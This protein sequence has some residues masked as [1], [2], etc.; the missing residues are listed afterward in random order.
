MLLSR[1]SVNLSELVFEITESAAMSNI[2]MTQIL[3]RQLR[4]LGCSC[5]LDNF[6]VGFSSFY[7]LK[8]FDVDYLKIDGS[9][10]SELATDE[11]SRLFVRSLCDV[12]KGLNKHVIAERVETSEVL[13]LLKPLGVDF[14]QGHHIAHPK[15]FIVPHE[16]GLQ[17]AQSA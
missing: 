9:F 13:A 15:P 16:I 2:E 11:A 8:R 12:A 1:T 17:A 14:A 4:E 7:Y 5:A 3:I 10:V 6:G